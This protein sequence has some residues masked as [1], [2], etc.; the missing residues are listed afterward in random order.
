MASKM[1]DEK[2]DELGELVETE[3]VLSIVTTSRAKYFGRVSES[4]KGKIIDSAYEITG[5]NDPHDIAKA[6]IKGMLYGDNRRIELSDSLVESVT[7][8]PD[9]T[10]LVRTYEAL[11]P[12]AR[13]RA[14][15]VMTFR[16]LEDLLSK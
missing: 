3:D 1:T 15:G 11:I 2:P 8:A 10:R 16:A 14:L 6:Y 5:Q 7:A 12:E 4:G 9:E 13:R